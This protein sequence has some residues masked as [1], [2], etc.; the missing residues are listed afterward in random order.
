MALYMRE[1]VLR[2]CQIV[3][4]FCFDS[5]RMGSANRTPILTASDFNFESLLQHRQCGV[6]WRGLVVAGFFLLRFRVDEVGGW[7][8]RL[9]DWNHIHEDRLLVKWIPASFRIIIQEWWRKCSVIKMLARMYC[10]KLLQY[11]HKWN[12]LFH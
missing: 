12:N 2:F 9:S 6:P 11:M 8:F 5:L 1:I 4:R 7:I 10:W 3:L